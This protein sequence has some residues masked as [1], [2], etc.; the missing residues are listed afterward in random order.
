MLFGDLCQLNPF[1]ADNKDPNI[2]DAL[3][4]QIFTNIFCLLLHLSESD[5]MIIR[6][7]IDWVLVKLSG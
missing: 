2:P 5:G 6:V 1:E 3:K 7:I 4:E